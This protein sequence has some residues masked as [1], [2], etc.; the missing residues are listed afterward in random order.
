M[1]KELTGD[2]WFHAGH[3]EQSPELKSCASS[4]EN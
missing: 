3:E 1:L 4:T 2:F